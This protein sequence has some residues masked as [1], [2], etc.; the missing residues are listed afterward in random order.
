MAHAL[1]LGRIP[2]R[3]IGGHRFFHTVRNIFGG[4]FL[5]LPANLFDDDHTVRLITFLK[6]PE[7]IRQSLGGCKSG[8]IDCMIGTALTMM[9]YNVKSKVGHH[10]QKVV[11]MIHRAETLCGCC[12]ASSYG[13]KDVFAV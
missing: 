13:A 10:R 6:E 11:D 8:E 7:N 9:E 12:L 4:L 2:S 1:S 3:N 5:L